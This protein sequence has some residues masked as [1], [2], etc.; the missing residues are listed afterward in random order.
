MCVFHVILPYGHAEPLI[1]FLL[2]A[3]FFFP[4][5]TTHTHTHICTHY[6]HTGQANQRER[7]K[8]K[9]DKY[10]CCMAFFT[11]L[12]IAYAVF[13]YLKKPF[14]YILIAWTLIHIEHWT[15]SW[16]SENNVVAS[17]PLEKK[18]LNWFLLMMIE[19]KTELHLR[20]KVQVFCARILPD[21]CNL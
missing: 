12:T 13:F 17:S 10:W 4:N 5:I 1:T 7:R 20:Q 15:V 2:R 21:R 8:A 3:Q 16:Y 9:K 19:K 6:T 18:N 14:F 11:F